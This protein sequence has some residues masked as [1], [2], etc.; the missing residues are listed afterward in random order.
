MLC[1]AANGCIGLAVCNSLQ[2]A[3]MIREAKERVLRVFPCVPLEELGDRDQPLLDESARRSI[4]HRHCPADTT[5]TR[6]V[7]TIGLVPVFIGE[8][9][10][11]PQDLNMGATATAETRPQEAHEA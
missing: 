6:P 9:E 11:L 3:I 8:K 2:T 10:A 4:G 1:D 5:N 7:R